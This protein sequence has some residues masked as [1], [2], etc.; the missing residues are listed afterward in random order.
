MV[1]HLDGPKETAAK[2][3]ERRWRNHD[4][5]TKFK[6]KKAEAKAAPKEPKQPLLIE[7]EKP[8]NDILIRTQERFKKEIRKMIDE[9]KRRNVEIYVALIAQEKRKLLKEKIRRLELSIAQNEARIAE[10]EGRSNG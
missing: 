5:A 2:R 8:K 4:I 6:A 7:T 9:H 10:R 1:K 3:A